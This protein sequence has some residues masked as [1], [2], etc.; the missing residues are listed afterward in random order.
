MAVCCSIRPLHPL[1]SSQGAPVKLVVPCLD[2][3]TQQHG[4]CT[5]WYNTWYV[6]R[7]AQCTKNVAFD[8]RMPGKKGSGTAD[9]SGRG[10]YAP[11][12]R[13][14]SCRDVRLPQKATRHTRPRPSVLPRGHGPASLPVFGGVITPM[15]SDR[16]ASPMVSSY[17]E[18][19][20]QS[21]RGGKCPAL[22]EQQ[23]TL[24]RAITGPPAPN[25]TWCP[26]SP[27]CT[28]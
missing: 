5:C 10:A 2:R 3:R 13:S 28:I 19:K 20:P 14:L 27:A 9:G 16:T 18:L 11:L 17:V 23:Y 12:P 8:F 26:K 6:T 21:S 24:T 1:L 4:T 25:Q 22:R 15:P 7:Q